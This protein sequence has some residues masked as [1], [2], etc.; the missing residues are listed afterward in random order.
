MKQYNLI[1]FLL[2]FLCYTNT[3]A[4]KNVLK[5]HISEQKSNSPLVGTSIIIPDLQLFSITDSNGNYQLRELPAGNYLVQVK[6]TGF[7]TIT[8]TIHISGITTENFIVSEEAIE[9]S[10]IV[11]TGSSKASQIKRNPVPI[12]SVSHDYLQTNLSTNVIDAIAKI[13]G[14]SA[15]TTGPNVSKP[16]IRGLGYNRI[17]TLYDGVRQEG[18]QWGEEHG[19]EVDQNGIDRIEVIKGPASLTYGSDA[20]AGV[21]NLIPTPAAPEGKK[22]GNAVFDYQSNNGLIGGSVV[23]GSTNKGFEF[24]GRISSKEATNYQNKID[25][26]VFNTAFK[27]SDA[28]LSLGLHGK[29]GY[30]HVGLSVFDD[31]QEVPDGSRDSATSKFTQQI[32][33]AD[34]FRP[35]VSASALKSYSITPLHQ[36]VQHYRAYITNNFKVGDG[37][38]VMNLG[39]QSSIRREFSHPEAPYQDVAGLYLQLRTFSYDIK[40][41]L[42]EYNGWNVS[43]GVNGMYQQNI[44][45][46]G[47]EFI[48]PSYHQ[49]DFGPFAL[50]KKT[51][52]KLDISGGIRYDTRSFKNDELYTKENAVNGFDKPVNGMDTIGANHPFYSYSHV[53]DGLS[54]SIGGTYN[55][56]NKLA[57]KL[58][59]SRGYRAPNIAEISANGVHPG[60]GFSQLGNTSFQSEFSLQEDIG[61]SY[62]TRKLDIEFSVFHNH[63]SNYIFNRRLM[64]AN[65]VGDSLTLSGNQYYPTY[66]FQQGAA[67]L[68][69][70]ELSIDIHPLKALH[71]ENSLSVV[72]AQNKSLDA[73]LTNDSNKYLPFIPPLHGISELR[74]DFSAKKYHLTH[75]FVKAQL[76]YYASQNRVYLT[77]NTETATAGYSLINVGIGSGITNNKGKTIA[78][79]SLMVN[80]L[81]DVAYRD[82]LSRLKYFYYSASDTNTNHGI[83]S[84]GRNIGIKLEVPFI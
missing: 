53:F 82:H 77:D 79:I 56:T 13:P 44:A 64:S 8:R 59:V 30:S 80:N 37:H 49:F 24:I 9:E 32:T 55:F 14:V 34:T 68:Y 22:M 11:I 71:F 42:P 84:M 73:K 33:E 3:N 26:R 28:G 39:Y 54:G 1:I 67:E 35:V 36:H 60:T 43:V 83:Y 16:V 46:N 17:L 76:A 12:V 21:V 50:I 27:E 81:F 18:Q 66:K 78:T 45:T 23:Y 75:G 4:Q 19:I 25:G 72:Y 70:G 52:N 31:I 65:G 40:Y 69:G 74:Y 63:I 2:V 10:A 6:Y 20:L 48:I 61:V 7:K 38:L 5:G 15:L 62:I 29:W 57:L 51:F 41:H 47:T 58:N